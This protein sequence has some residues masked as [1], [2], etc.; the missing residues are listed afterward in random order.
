MDNIFKGLLTEFE[1]I[2]YLKE[3]AADE[4]PSSKAGP[5]AR[6]MDIPTPPPKPGIPTLPSTGMSGCKFFLGGHGCKKG[7][8]CKY[9]ND[10]KDIPKQQRRSKC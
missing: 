7:N 9:A 1:Q 3:G 2:A 5:K 8:K 6:S 4:G 10:W